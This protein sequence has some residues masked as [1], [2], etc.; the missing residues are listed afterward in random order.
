MQQSLFA[1]KGFVTLDA[2]AAIEQR[3]QRLDAYRDSRPSLPRETA[4]EIRSKKEIRDRSRAKDRKR[5]ERDLKKRKE[6]SQGLR[7]GTTGKKI[8][9]ATE[10][11]TDGA[12]S[13]STTSAALSRVGY[14]KNWSS[15][16]GTRKGSIEKPPKHTNWYHPFLWKRIDAAARRTHFASSALVHILQLEDSDLFKTLW[17]STVDKWIDKESKKRGWKSKTLKHVEKNTIAHQRGRSTSSDRLELIGSELEP[18]SSSDSDSSEE[19]SEEAEGETSGEMG[20]MSEGSGEK[21]DGGV[22]EREGEEVYGDVDEE[23]GGSTGNIVVAQD[24]MSISHLL[25]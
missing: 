4:E 7:D 6:I 10:L 18:E 14:S 3:R 5:K 20:E 15:R 21:E 23:K 12:T 19:M 8:H 2:K 17:P 25:N 1:F 9:R 22:S 24:K 11:G 13:N 16:N